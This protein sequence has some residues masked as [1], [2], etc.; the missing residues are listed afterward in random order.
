MAISYL[1]FVVLSLSIPISRYYN[2]E[3][4]ANVLRMNPLLCAVAQN[5]DTSA[6]T[7]RLLPELV[8]ERSSL[9]TG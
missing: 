6:I 7:S 5:Q 1:N 4:G 9:R 3:R 2:C 8:R